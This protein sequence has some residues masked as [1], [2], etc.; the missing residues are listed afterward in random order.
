MLLTNYIQDYIQRLRARRAIRSYGSY[1]NFVVG[2]DKNEKSL[3]M[4]YLASN[5]NKKQRELVKSQ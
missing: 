2:A 3:V 4:S 1:A 5:A